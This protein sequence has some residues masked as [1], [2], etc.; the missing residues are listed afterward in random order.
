MHP[1]ADTFLSCSLDNS[2]RLWDVNTPHCT[3][4]L[5]LTSPYLAA[6]DPSASV[7]AIASPSTFSILLYDY[8]KFD[9]KPFTTIDVLPLLKDFLP[10]AI[11]RHW[12][13]LEFSNDG[14]SLLLG[15]SGGGHF[16]LDAFDGAVRALLVR[17]HGT[18]RLAPGQTAE[19]IAD[20]AGDVCFSPDGN[21][22]VSG[23][24]ERNVLVYDINMPSATKKLTP[25]HELEFRGAAAVVAF[26][27]RF[28][29]FASADKE[30]VFWLPDQL[31]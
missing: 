14:K 31:A 10:R 24:G 28:N 22:V 7:I 25:V 11:E 4:K 17:D 29:M 12:T 26:N 23:A 8:R 20:S 30:T 15:L 18:R 13:K 27:P 19:G 2:V 16:V 21:F 1:G 5:Y 6:F 3:G 9:E